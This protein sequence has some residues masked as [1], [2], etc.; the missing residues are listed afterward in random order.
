[1]SVYHN[2]QYEEW[3]CSLYWRDWNGNHIKKTYKVN[4]NVPIRRLLFVFGTCTI[5]AS[6]TTY[7]CCDPMMFIYIN[8]VL[9]IAKKI[10]LSIY[11]KFSVCIK[12]FVKPCDSKYYQQITLIITILV[13]K[14][15]YNEISAICIRCPLHPES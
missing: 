11:I 7:R 10:I 12:L 3:W 4:I 1:M 14:V 9:I 6:K 2:M 15:K 13:C 5:Q 8:L